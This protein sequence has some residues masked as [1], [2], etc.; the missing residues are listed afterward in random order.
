[1]NKWNQRYSTTATPGSVSCVLREF[2]HLLPPNGAALDIA[3]GLG[4][5]ALLL[6]QRGLSVHAWDSSNVAIE[7]LS[8]FAREKNLHID[9]Q[10]R[11][12]MTHPPEPHSFDVIV[13]SHFLERTLCPHIVAA[14]KPRGLLFYQTFC[15]ERV[16]A[17][18]GPSNPDFLLQKNELLR[19]F[20]PLDVVAYQ[21]L[22]KLGDTTQGLRDRAVLIAQKPAAS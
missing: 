22:G 15:A 12:V 9:A 8:H 19:L 11:D 16:D 13:V 10:C 18:Y 21:E 6:A 14:L 3:C 20:A 2:T 5:D 17:S 7:K 4:A 1:M